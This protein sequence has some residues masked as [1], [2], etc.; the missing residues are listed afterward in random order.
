M[1]PYVL[2]DHI[3]DSDL[4]DIFPD[5][6][7]Y[8]D[9]MPDIDY[10]TWGQGDLYLCFTRW[11]DEFPHSVNRIY[12]VKGE[13]SIF[14]FT[15]VNWKN[16]GEHNS[17]ACISS[18]NGYHPRI[19]IGKCSA[20]LL[21]PDLT[22]D[23]YKA[24]SYTAQIPFQF[25]PA[26]IVCHADWYPPSWP[27]WGLY[28]YAWRHWNPAWQSFAGGCTVVDIGPPSANYG[29]VVWTQARDQ[30]LNNVTVAFI[31]SRGNAINLH[32]FSGQ[33][34]PASCMGSV[35]V[36]NYTSGD[37]QSSI[38][39]FWKETVQGSDPWLPRAVLLCADPYGIN[40]IERS[41]Q[42]LAF[43]ENVHCEWNF[44]TLVDHYYGMNCALTVFD[45]DYW[46]VWSGFQPPGGSPNTVW[47]T[48]GNTYY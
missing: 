41:E 7:G 28:E 26:I 16:D 12:L 3:I 42:E 13:R 2:Q 36:H 38:S 22:Y 24:I 6:G 4:G 25:L 1:T 32:D 37:I 15:T 19:A 47:G 39:Y 29:A 35:A 34:N 45:T 23:W 18:R 46:M 43:S 44:G 20:E 27:P 14:G 9:I 11:L 8:G 5:H 31:D 33:N 40:G 21:H 17:A 30:G 10:H 48:Y